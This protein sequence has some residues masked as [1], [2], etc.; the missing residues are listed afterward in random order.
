MV[1]EKM[2]KLIIN[3]YFK[4]TN[5]IIKSFHAEYLFQEPQQFLPS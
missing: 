1:M 5:I 4:L 3:N 2:K